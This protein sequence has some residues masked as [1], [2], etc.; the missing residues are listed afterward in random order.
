MRRLLPPLSPPRPE[1]E[2]V[3][4][5]KIAE[6]LGETRMFVRAKL[7]FLAGSLM[8]A[9]L[10]MQGCLAVVWV[11][12][13]GFDS[14]R[15]SEIEFQPF[16]NSWLAPP[17]TRPNLDSVTSIAVTPFLETSPAHQEMPTS[18]HLDARWTGLLQRGTALH[19]ISPSEVARQVEPNVMA[20]LKDATDQEQ[21]RLAPRISEASGASYVLF[22]RVV[23]EQ[24]NKSM[25]G[26]KEKQSKRLYLYL[27]SADGTLLWKDELPFKLVKGAKNLDEQW[28][29]QALR[30]HVAAHAQELG[31]A[32][33][34]LQFKK[35]GS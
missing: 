6:Q 10:C 22:G 28:E 1:N 24:Q 12:A 31:L 8:L 19:V 35:T 21:L 17:E 3:Y 2:T 14:I 23:E 33:L 34:G 30:A 27:T 13:V 16:E 26:L 11:G 15:S 29:A 25:S 4:L 7:V 32:D 18:E 9:S 5:V 20:S